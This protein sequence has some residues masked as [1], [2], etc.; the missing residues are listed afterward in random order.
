MVDVRQIVSKVRVGGSFCFAF[1]IQAVRRNVRK[2]GKRDQVALRLYV[3]VDSVNLLNGC[4][5][6]VQRT[7]LEVRYKND[8]PTA[9]SVRPTVRN[10]VEN[11]VKSV[12]WIMKYFDIRFNTSDVVLSGVNFDF[13][14][15][16]VA[17]HLCSL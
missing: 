3:S 6:R 16:G 9:A 12:I 15:R 2:V 1:W 5:C 11:F 4:V 7:K 14:V 17:R 8:Q 10:L 13:N